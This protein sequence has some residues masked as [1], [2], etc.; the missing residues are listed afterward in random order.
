MTV[1]LT[2]YS[3]LVCTL[4]VADKGLSLLQKGIIK[5]TAASIFVSLPLIQFQRL[6][7]FGIWILMGLIFSW[8]G[9]LCL[10]WRGTG[11]RFKL[12]ILAFLLAHVAYGVAFIFAHFEPERATVFFVCL[13]LLGI[14]IYGRLKAD[15]QPSIRPAVMVYLFA[16]TA[17]TAL[18]WSLVDSEARFAFGFSATAFLVS[19]ISVALQRFGS[20]SQHHRLWGIPLYFG[21]QISFA[22]LITEALY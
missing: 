6:T 3:L 18:A 20:H 19:D 14:V 9:D 13:G 2:T 5:M 7:S 15:M 1:L 8:I 17:M 16:L 10:I 21:A 12:G 4:A 22:I 11:R